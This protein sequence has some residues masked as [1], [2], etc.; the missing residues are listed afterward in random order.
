MITVTKHEFR[1]IQGERYGNCIFITQGN[2]E[3]VNFHAGIIDTELR[4]EY[5]IK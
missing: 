3:Q 1:A 5:I 4:K 2:E